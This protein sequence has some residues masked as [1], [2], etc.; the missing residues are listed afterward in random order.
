MSW[1]RIMLV[2]NV[3]VTNYDDAKC[4]GVELCWCKMSWC[5]IMLMQNVL[6][7]NYDDAKCLGVKSC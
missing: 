2:Q 1:C 4:L 5:R 3:L 6:V 7:T